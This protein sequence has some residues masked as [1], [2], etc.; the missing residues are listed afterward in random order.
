[1]SNYRGKVDSMGLSFFGSMT[2]SIS[3]EM[4]NALAVINENA[5]L[6]SDLVGL[7]EKGRPLNPE[8][9]KMISENV[10]K[11]VQQ[12]DNIVRRL[13]RFAHSANQPVVAVDIREIFDFTIALATRL[14]SMKGITLVMAIDEAIQIQ[15]L[16]FFVENLLW[17]CL[18]KAFQ[19][20]QEGAQEIAL[21]ASIEETDVIITLQFCDAFPLA[22]LESLIAAEGQP[23]IL[24]L[25]CHVSTDAATNQLRLRMFRKFIE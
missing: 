23:L 24:F 4:K 15:T 17:L 3:H 6:L 1:M 16:P 13:N 10:L 14:A 12:A 11:R 22:Q 7:A 19:L 25:R 2:A 8:R 9:I 5:G 21:G 20:A 18:N